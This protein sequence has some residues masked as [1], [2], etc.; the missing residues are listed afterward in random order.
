MKID[1]MLTEIDDFIDNANSVKDLTL[2]KLLSDG[3]ITEDQYRLYNECHQIIVIK[4]SWFKTWANKFR[5]NAEKG[6]YQF[7]Y[8]KFEDEPIDLKKDDE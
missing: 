8:V 4:T 2:S 1:S 6:N 5:P 7:K 3:I